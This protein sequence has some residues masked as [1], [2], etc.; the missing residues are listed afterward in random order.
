LEKS[1]T[2][3]A[4]EKP[5]FTPSYPAAAPPKGGWVGKKKN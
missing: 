4:A 1:S 3:T 5:V 2:W